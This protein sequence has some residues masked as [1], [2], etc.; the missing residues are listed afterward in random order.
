MNL[1]QLFLPANSNE[2]KPF[3]KELFRDIE[4][5][6]TACFGGVTSYVHMP[7]RGLWK[8]SADNTIHD[9]IILIE[10]MTGTIDETFWKNYKIQLENLFQQSEIIIRVLSINLL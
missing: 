1:I 8:E 4:K 6:L 5:E 10:V 3:S 9:E 7:A 2:G